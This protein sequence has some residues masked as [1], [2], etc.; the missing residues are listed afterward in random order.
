MARHGSIAIRGLQGCA[1]GFVK[2]SAM[3]GAGIS[4][5]L[6]S[7]LHDRGL[8]G[9]GVAAGAA[10]FSNSMAGDRDSKMQKAL[11]V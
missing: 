11:V 7:D 8:A 2:C 4:I 10:G 6:Y 5:R 9:L 1:C 3:V